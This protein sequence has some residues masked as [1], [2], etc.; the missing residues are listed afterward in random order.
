ML[1]VVSNEW[2]ERQTE[3]NLKRSHRTDQSASRTELCNVTCISVLDGKMS[4]MTVP[5]G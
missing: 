2:T 5:L 4:H 3:L 1:F